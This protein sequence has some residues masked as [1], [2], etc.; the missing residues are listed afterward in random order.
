MRMKHLNIF[1]SLISSLPFLICRCQDMS[2]GQLGS[3]SEKH[4]KVNL[5]RLSGQNVRVIFYNTE[6]LYDPHEDSTKHDDEFTPAGAKRWTYSRL[7]MKL[8][9]LAKTIMAIGEGDLPALIGLSEVEN[10]YVL[11][12]LIYDSPLKRFHYR[13]IH[14]DSPDLRGV[15]VAL[16]YRPDRFM[17]LTLKPLRIRFPFDTLARTRDILMVSGIL[18]HS[19]T[20]NIFVNHWPSKLGGSLESEKRRCYVAGRLRRAVDSVFSTTQ[21]ANILIMGDFND[22]PDDSSVRVILCRGGSE[23]LINLMTDK[24][25]K[26][27]GTHKFQGS[28]SVIDQFIVSASLVKG[29]HGIHLQT[30][31]AMIFNAGFL[32]ENEHSFLGQKPLRTYSGPNYLGGFSDHLPIYL[33][34]WKK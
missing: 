25:H 3:S 16:L 31:G 23:A 2:Q 19:D 20:V 10:R 22:E 7:S 5:T 15:D 30:G 9:H 18:F 8:T 29:D 1:L 34:L 32:L 11:N 14:Y 26:N 4:A 27:Y 17:P 21:N 6:N 33:D 24:Q 28:W 13:I 12:R